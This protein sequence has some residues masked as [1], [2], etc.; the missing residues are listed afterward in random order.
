MYANIKELTLTTLKERKEAKYNH[1]G[2]SFVKEIVDSITDKR[3]MPFLQYSYYDYGVRTLIEGTRSNIS[4]DMIVVIGLDDILK[5]RDGS[6]LKCKTI[7]AKT[8]TTIKCIMPDEEYHVT[9]IK[10]LNKLVNNGRY[11][12]SFLD[13]KEVV[14]EFYFSSED[15]INTGKIGGLLKMPSKL[16]NYY[17]VID[18][19][20]INN[21]HEFTVVVEGDSI[22]NFIITGHTKDIGSHYILKWDEAD[23]RNYFAISK[24]I[25]SDNGEIIKTSIKQAVNQVMF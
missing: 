14:R 4:K 24:N 13:N 3:L 11:K 1:M 16:T 10:F 22:A 20:T 19:T 5:N 23:A 21:K 15:L 9:G 6:S 7:L 18:N 2:Y 25:V 12:V 8:V 17:E